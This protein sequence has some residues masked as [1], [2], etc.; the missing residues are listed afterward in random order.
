MDSGG[1]WV[2]RSL[3]RRRRRWARAASGAS[4]R[5][6]TNPRRRRCASYPG[7]WSGLAH[8]TVA[9]GLWT[10]GSRAR[11]EGRVRTPGWGR[12]A[13]A[14]G[15]GR[16]HFP[17]SPGARCGGVWRTRGIRSGLRRSSGSSKFGGEGPGPGPRRPLPRAP[18]PSTVRPCPARIV[19]LGL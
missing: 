1:G 14:P 8:V 2:Q 11:P 15:R 13:G 5:P 18:L 16:G 7:G 10:G 9:C 12:S 6:G 3:G 17:F 19:W 4:H